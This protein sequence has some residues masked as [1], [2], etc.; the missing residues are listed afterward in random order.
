MDEHSDVY[1]RNRFTLTRAWLID[2]TI[3]YYTQLRHHRVSIHRHTYTQVQ[4]YNNQAKRGPQFKGTWPS[5]VGRLKPPHFFSNSDL[6]TTY[7]GVWGGPIL[8]ADKPFTM[9]I[10]VYSV[11]YQ[12]LLH[13]FESSA[14]G[15]NR[16]GS[17]SVY[18]RYASS[19]RESSYQM[20]VNHERHRRGHTTPM[21]ASPLTAVSNEL[22]WL[23]QTLLLHQNL[24]SCT[25]KK[26]VIS[27]PL[28]TIVCTK[29][30]H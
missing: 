22:V 18:D 21:A 5:E 7:Y 20:V 28:V 3:L 12:V 14:S 11:V 27:L 6:W 1:A 4:H 10:H 2:Y 16:T 30:Q 8:V 19:L 29:T 15:K 9:N 24:M 17:Q 26:I 13:L 25:M 23:N